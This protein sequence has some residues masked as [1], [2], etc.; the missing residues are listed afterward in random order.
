MDLALEQLTK[1]QIEYWKQNYGTAYGMFAAID[2]N[3]L[4]ENVCIT[5][6]KMQKH[7]AEMVKS[8]T[9]TEYNPTA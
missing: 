3:I 4:P 1:A 5:L 6:C 2:R 9:P 7:C 8:Q